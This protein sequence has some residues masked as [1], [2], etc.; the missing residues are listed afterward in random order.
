VFTPTSY[1]LTPHSLPPGKIRDHPP[2]RTLPIGT[3]DMNGLGASDMGFEHHISGMYPLM[4]YLLVVEGF[5]IEK[6]IEFHP[7]NT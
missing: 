2:R 6:S 1:L 7:L 3:D 5:G 4:V